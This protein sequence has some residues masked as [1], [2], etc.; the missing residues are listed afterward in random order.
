LRRSH[1]DADHTA[2]AE[3]VRTFITKEITPNYAD[4]ERAGIAPRE[5]FAAAGAAGLLGLDVPESHGGMGIADF[6]FNQVLGEELMLHSI[7]GAGIGLT[8]HNDVCMPYFTECAND[9]QRNRW[10]PGLASGQLIAAVAMTEPGAGSDLAACAPPPY[11]TVVTS[12]ST[13]ARRS[14][15]TD[16]MPTWL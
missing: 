6:R 7:G 16:T 4:W 5:L 3:L 2:F 13:A 14:S 15:P 8:L 12:S 10:L 9:E 11:P 1:F